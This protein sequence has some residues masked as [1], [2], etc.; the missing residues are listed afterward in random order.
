MTGS[1]TIPAPF[2]APSAGDHPV[3]QLADG[4]GGVQRLLPAAAPFRL[5]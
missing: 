3:T 1:R 4:R 5:T 2:L